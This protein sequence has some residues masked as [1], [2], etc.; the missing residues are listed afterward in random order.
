MQGAWPAAPP[1][2]DRDVAHAAAAAGHDE[3]TVRRL[4]DRLAAGP[5][6]PATRLD[7]LRLVLRQATNTCG[8]A[9]LIVARALLDPVYAMWLA[10][11]FDA[12][13]PGAAADERPPAARFAAAEPQVMA[14]TN[15]ALG[16]RGLRLPWPASLGTPPW[17]ASG[18]MT[19]IGG[20]GGVRYVARA[21]DPDSTDSRQAGYRAAEAAALAGRPAPLFVGDDATPRHSVLVVGRDGDALRLYEPAAGT[22]VRVPEAQLT[23][24]GLRVAGW[25]RFWAVVVPR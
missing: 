15:A 13:T 10:E 18:Q 20:P 1:E 4:L 9:T 25:G 24:A 12:R 23:G 14:R 17:G 19:R 21:V 3:A 2:R 6:D 22:V 16:P 5:G 11:G 8:A 7:P